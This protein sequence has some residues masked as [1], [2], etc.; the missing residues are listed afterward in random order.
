MQQDRRRGRVGQAAVQ[1]RLALGEGA[2]ARAATPFG[3]RGDAVAGDG[4]AGSRDK[5]DAVGGEAGADAEVQ[6]LVGAAERRVEPAEGAPGLPAHE[7]SA[8]VRAQHVGVAVVL[9]LVELARGQLDR[10]AVA[11]HADAEGDDLSAVVPLDELGSGDG[12]RRGELE[13]TGQAL[14]RIRLGGG[15]L[16]EQ[17]DGV[18]GQ[19]G[20]GQRG[21]PGER[22][23]HGGGDDAFRS[24]GGGDLGQC[25]V[26]AAQDDRERI[27]RSHLRVE[28]GQRALQVERG[29]RAS[30]GAHDEDGVDSRGHSVV[31]LGGGPGE[32]RR[33]AGRARIRRGA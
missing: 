17:P 29:G 26:G 21:R 30:L 33:R 23:A 9:A 13:R 24:G 11:G 28:R 14:Q 20:R 1:L 25:R 7:Q 4:D 19:P 3:H 16:R 32:R 31:S 15:V 8:D 10:A 5:R 18:A 2:A 12:E 27:D 6:P 22:G